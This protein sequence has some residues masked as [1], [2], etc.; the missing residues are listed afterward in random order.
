WQNLLLPEIPD[1][2]V[3]TVKR[4]LVRIGFHYEATNIAGGLI[5]CTGNTGCKW[6]AT[7]TKGQ[8]LELAAYLDQRVHLDHP[9]NI[10][11]TGCPNSCAQ[12][13][14]GDIGCLGTKTKIAGQNVDA[15]HVFVGG[16]FG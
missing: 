16:G 1:G 5:T 12:H 10:H 2:F 14:I 9:L 6:A 8:A 13:Y 4:Q 3:E 11:F 7:D 15:Y